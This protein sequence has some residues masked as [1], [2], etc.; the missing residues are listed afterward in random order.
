M[1]CFMHLVFVALRRVLLEQDFVIVIWPSCS[2]SPLNY[3]VYYIVAGFY[4]PVGTAWHTSV[5]VENKLYV[6]AG[7][8]D[9]IPRVHSSEAKLRATSYVDVFECRLGM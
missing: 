5:L 6:W 2:L 8:R 9:D 7:L 3:Y 4:Q 1:Y